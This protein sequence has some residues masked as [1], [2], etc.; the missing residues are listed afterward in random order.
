MISGYVPAETR[1][2]LKT[3]AARPD[4][5]LQQVKAD[6]L[7]AWL[8]CHDKEGQHGRGV[9]RPQLGSNCEAWSTKQAHGM[10]FGT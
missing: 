10:K 1:R 3:V 6:A 7:E 2:R 4:K 5:S 9:Q 8:R